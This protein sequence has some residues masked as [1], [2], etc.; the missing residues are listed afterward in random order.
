VS[1][2]D[3]A[4]R[5]LA[6]R[7]GAGRFV[8]RDRG[9][10][11]VRGRDRVRWLDGMLSNDVARLRPGRAS[12][13][14]YALLLTPQG[15][16]VCDF[17]VIQRGD[18]FW[19]ETEARGLPEIL[20][21]LERHIIADDVT[22]EDRSDGIARIALEG[23]AAPQVLARA[24]GETPGLAPECAD[25]FTCAGRR[26]CVVAFGWSGA[27]GF[28][29]I[30]PADAEPSLTAALRAAA[31]PD[32]ELVEGDAEVLEILRIEAG[33][34]RLH[35]ELDSNVLPPEAGLMARAVALQKGCYTG[36]EIV[37]RIHSRGAESHRLVSLR[38]EGSEP[39]AGTALRAEERVVGSVTSSC[40]S[41]TA[42]PIG[43]G[44][45]RR[46]FDAEGSALLADGVAARVAVPPLVAPTGGA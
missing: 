6:A 15:R 39:V 4:T 24:L 43:L 7:R 9:L 11:A 18:E 28:Q 37:A 44:F 31:A 10:I 35:R 16:I 12:S 36:Q 29:L 2:D 32:V 3:A 19:L 33:I 40:H 20:A 30:A 25:D 23:A 8:L 5:A 17:H 14:C 41:A 42:G 45:V 22:L 1:A 21:R 46:P 38:F 27:P 26:I 13:G 34:P